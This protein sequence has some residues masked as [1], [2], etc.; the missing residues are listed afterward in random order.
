MSALSA[1]TSAS[2]STPHFG[3]DQ[4]RHLPGWRHPARLALAAI[5]VAYTLNDALGGVYAVVVFNSTF[6]MISRTTPTPSLPYDE[7]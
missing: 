6:D 7:L 2:K 4:R 5:M 1:P 3:P